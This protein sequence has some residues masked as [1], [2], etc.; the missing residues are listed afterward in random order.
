MV[1]IVGI[2]SDVTGGESGRESLYASSATQFLTASGTTLILSKRLPPPDTLT[3]TQCVPRGTNRLGPCGL[4]CLGG[5][6]AESVRIS[7]EVLDELESVRR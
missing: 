1:P 7:K 3:R 2:G 6:G 4:D 5:E